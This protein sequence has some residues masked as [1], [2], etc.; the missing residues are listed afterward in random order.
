MSINSSGDIESLAHLQKINARSVSQPSGRKKF[1]NEN[2][3][4]K[5]NP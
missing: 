2:K 3:I 4:L 5:L 1:G